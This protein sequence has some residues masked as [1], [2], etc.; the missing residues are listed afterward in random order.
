MSLV[1]VADATDPSLK[2]LLPFGE[3]FTNSTFP[4]VPEQ[5]R[6][7]PCSLVLPAKITSATAVFIPAL[8]SPAGL[9]TAVIEAIVLKYL[10]PV[11]VPAL[12]PVMDSV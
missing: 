9:P 11:A 7:I 8:T 6:L 12:A 2:R 5:T 1:T 4:A 10:D 3:V